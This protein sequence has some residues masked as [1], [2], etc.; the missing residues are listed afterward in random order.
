MDEGNT[1][2]ELH[3]HL[4]MWTH[5]VT[6]Q[7]KNI[8]SL[9]PKDLWA[10][11]KSH[12]PLSMWSCDVTCHI[13]HIMSLLLR[14]LW[15]PNFAGWWLREEGIYPWSHM[16]I[17]SCGHM[18]NKRANTNISS[19]AMA[20]GDHKTSWVDCPHHKF[21]ICIVT[22]W[23]ASCGC[24]SPLVTFL[25]VLCLFLLEIHTQFLFTCDLCF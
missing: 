10:P 8:V 11:M 22:T 2:M 23:L 24:P 7:I 13:K 5:E 12:N 6:W 15:P 25:H 18:T 4:I 9:L 21:L 3:D 20:T 1:L 19:C 17:W 16:T 14:D